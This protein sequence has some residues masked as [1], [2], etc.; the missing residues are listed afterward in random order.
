MDALRGASVLLVVLFHSTIEVA[1]SGSQMVGPVAAFNDAVAPFRMPTMVFLSGILLNRSLRKDIRA[2]ANGKL[3]N[4]LWP[5]A[6]W[7]LIYLA[8]S[9]LMDTA[10]DGPDDNLSW[11][12][13]LHPP[14][15]MWF[16]QY[17]LIFY[18][19]A[20]AWARLKWYWQLLLTVG[21]FTL[22]GF[23]DGG[24]ARFALLLGC[25][26]LGRLAGDH[27]HVWRALT[28][29]TWVAAVACTVVA[30]GVVVALRSSSLDAQYDVADL[31]F[32]L[33]GIILFSRLSM[34]LSSSRW[35]RPLVAAGRD[36]L[37]I[38]LTHWLFVNAAI[39]TMLLVA[40]RSNGLLLLAVAVA[41][42]VLG[43][44]LVLALTSRSPTLRLAFSLRR[45]R[46]TK[47]RESIPRQASQ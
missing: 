12:F 46:S 25:F 45:E 33:S 20:L 9:Q 1:A 26:I 5:F 3:R 13:V 31:P 24:L 18:A 14:G 4:I 23:A 35:S 29:R 6:V 42:G 38:Y 21:A 22:A 32:I 44:S 47:S 28:T 17:L 2:Y 37:I 34:R 41:A 8:V 27:V 7:S 43:S 11:N 19:S 39:D 36:S 40:P 10:T 15:V 30:G 16:L